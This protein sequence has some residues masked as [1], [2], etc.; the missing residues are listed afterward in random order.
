VIVI[1]GTAGLFAGAL[2][3][4]AGEFVSVTSQRELLEHQLSLERAE[5]DMYPD[6]EAAELALI[7]EARGLPKGQAESLSKQLVADP[8]RGLATLAREELGID[9]ENLGSPIGAA[10]SSFLAF[11]IGAAIPLIPFLIYRHSVVM[12]YSIGAAIVALFITGC[13]VGFISGRGLLW[14]GA[15]MVLI[16]G[17][18]G[19]LSYLIGRLT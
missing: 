8:A 18:A 7:Y 11:T 10:V 1:S 2:S 16:G 4:A 5:L 9:P 3:M 6:E 15:R 14:A 19:V 17:G 12:P 13:I